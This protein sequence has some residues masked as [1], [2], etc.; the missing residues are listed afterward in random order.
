M[1]DSAAHAPATGAARPATL[2]G[3]RRAGD[4]VRAL[5]GLLSEPVPVL[6]ELGERFDGTLELRAREIATVALD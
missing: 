3:P 4:R 1:T 6:D 2:P 5:R